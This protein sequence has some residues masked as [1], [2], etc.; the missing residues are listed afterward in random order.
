VC[1]CVC[2]TKELA[3]STVSAVTGSQTSWRKLQAHRLEY[4]INFDAL[5]YWPR[6]HQWAC[7]CSSSCLSRCS[8]D[9]SCLLWSSSICIRA[10]RRPLCCR[11]SLASA[12]SS[13]SRALCGD[14]G[15]ISGGDGSGDSP[16][17]SWAFFSRSYSDCSFL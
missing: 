10:S 3:Q 6:T 16:F 14:A 7:T 11:S 2:W 9:S 5:L 17:L 4:D 15:S 13:A 8:W 12:M 1:V